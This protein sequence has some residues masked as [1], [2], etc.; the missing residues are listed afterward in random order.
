MSNEGSQ[1]M[2][3]VD[4]EAKALERYKAALDFLKQPLFAASNAAHELPSGDD[5]VDDRI[6]ALGWIAFMASELCNAKLQLLE[7][8]AHLLWKD[9]DHGDDEHEQ[10]SN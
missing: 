7:S 9:D 8:I 2:T 10:Q 4:D 5:A 6:T 1:D 3:N